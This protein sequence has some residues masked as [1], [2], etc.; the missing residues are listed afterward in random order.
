MISAHSEAV[1]FRTSFSNGKLNEMTDAP[2]NHGGKGDGFLPFELLEA[3]LAT[4]M[5]ITLRVYAQSH[6]IDLPGLETRVGIVPDGE[7]HAFEYEIIFDE[8]PA[9]EQKK[10][11]LAA[12]KGCPIHGVLTKPISI[13]P[14]QG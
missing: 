1:N 3:S 14:K 7:G 6:G 12:V 2:E 13:R 11:L 10:R 5:N 9:P 8:E 4:C